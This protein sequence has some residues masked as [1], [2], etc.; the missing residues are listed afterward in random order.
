MACEAVGEDGSARPCREPIHAWGDSPLHAQGLAPL[1]LPQV[2]ADDESEPTGRVRDPAGGEG[3]SA[4][5]STPRTADE[6]IA[7]Y[8]EERPGRR[9]LPAAGP[10][11]SSRCAS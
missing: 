4:E 3:V 2:R 5:P 1:P 7:E 11:A 8:D 10:D 6:L 9:A